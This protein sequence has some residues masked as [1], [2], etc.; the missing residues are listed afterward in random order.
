MGYVTPMPN[1]VLGP[2]GAAVEG[3]QKE[4]VWVDPHPFKAPP[5]KIQQRYKRLLDKPAGYWRGI[6]WRDDGRLAD[7]RRDI[8]EQGRVRDCVG[9]AVASAVRWHAILA[10]RGDPG[11]L[12]PFLVWRL[13]QERNPHS[14][15]P[16][17]GLLEDALMVTS[18]YGI[19][20]W[21]SNEPEVPF[22]DATKVVNANQ[23][24]Y[25]DDYWKQKI[26]GFVNLGAYLGD[27]GLYLHARGPIVVQMNVAPQTFATAPTLTY[28]EEQEILK[29]LPK[30][31]HAPEGWSSHAVVVVGFRDAFDKAHPSSFVVLNSYGA[32]WGD[33]GYGYIDVKTAQRAFVRGYGLVLREHYGAQRET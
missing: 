6:D 23:D 24:A 13:A 14:R 28:P 9:F 22:G 11:R 30:D 27:W 8:Y 31:G 16:A 26:Q 5:D 25:L 32:G 18:N 2:A 33:G 1:V 20:P 15:S 29:T 3:H 4:H 17:W 10:G 7:A 21:R 19:R 12:D